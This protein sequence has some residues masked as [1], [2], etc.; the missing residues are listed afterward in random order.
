MDGEAAAKPAKERLGDINDRSVWIKRW[1]KAA[2]E[3]LGPFDREDIQRRIHETSEE[4]RKLLRKL[5]VRKP[6]HI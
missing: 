4:M 2:P 3:L 5:Q 6:E 1:K